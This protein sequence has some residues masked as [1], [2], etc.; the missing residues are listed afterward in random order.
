MPC[1]SVVVSFIRSTARF[2]CSVYIPF[3]IH[4]TQSHT[5]SWFLWFTCFWVCKTYMVLKLR[6]KQ[7]NIYYEK[8]HS[9]SS[10][11]HSHSLSFSL[12]STFWKSLSVHPGD[13]HSFSE[14]HSTVCKC[15]M[16]YFPTL[17]HEYLGCSRYSAF[18]NNAEINTLVHVYFCIIWWD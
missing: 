16:V 15:S 17:L 1:F 18:S 14:L 3:W 11:P 12:Y 8:C 9:P 2:F 5:P 7:K 13:P 6:T 10:L 4:H